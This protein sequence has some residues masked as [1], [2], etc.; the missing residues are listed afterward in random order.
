MAPIAGESLLGQTAHE[1]ADAKGHEETDHTLR[2]FRK[3]SESMR[4]VLYQDRSFSTTELHFIDNLFQVLQMAHLRWK[5]KHWAQLPK[6]C[7]S[8]CS[9]PYMSRP[10]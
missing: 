8:A 5:R 2:E 10:I 9:L 6:E 7:P 3:C 1:M 4:D